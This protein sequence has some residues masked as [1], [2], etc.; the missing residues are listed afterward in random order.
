MTATQTEPSSCR[1]GDMAEMLFAAGAIV[2]DW[3]I[4]MPFGHAQTTDV[5][6]LRPWTTPIKVQVKT[7]WWD[8]SHQSY[9][10]FVRNGS[11]QAYAFGDF[12][13][14][15]AYLSDINQ[16]VFWAFSDISGR[17]KIRYSPERHRKPSNWEL[18][19]D[20]AKSLARPNT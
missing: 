7:A 12:D 3:E 18:L 4:Y 20:V 19:D 14:L 15:A 10:V 5:C 2:H 8:A 6:L 11:K 16:F 1:K 17:Q 13:V 9:A